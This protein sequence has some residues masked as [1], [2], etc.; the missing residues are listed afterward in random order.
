MKRILGFKKHRS[1]GE[2]VEPT[3]LG[4]AEVVLPQPAGGGQTG[5]AEGTT[6]K[7]MEAAALCSGGWGTMAVCYGQST[8]QVGR[9]MLRMEREKGQLME[10][11][12]V[13]WSLTLY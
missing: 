5:R 3:S 2:R 6:V 12:Y 11:L 7:M 13:T 8:E 10:D 4:D 1:W 9:V